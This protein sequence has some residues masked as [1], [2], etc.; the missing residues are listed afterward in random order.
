MKA[1]FHIQSA[2]LA[3]LCLIQSISGAQTAP[4]EGQFIAHEW[5]TFTAVQGSNG[6]PLGGMNHEEEALPSF[7]I[8]RDVLGETLRRDCPRTKGMPICNDDVSGPVIHSGDVTQKMETPVLYFHSDRER[9]VNVQIDFPQGIISQYFPRPLYF[10]PALNHATSLAGGSATFQVHIVNGALPVP[11]VEPLSVYRP[12]REVEANYLSANGENEKFIF[13]RGLGHFATS[14]SVSSSQGDLTL[15]NR[16]GERLEAVFLL[17]VSPQG[18]G[19]I[20]ALGGVE[21]N[22]ALTVA[23]EDVQRLTHAQSAP[24]VFLKNAQS[25]INAALERSGLYKDEAAA[26]TNTWKRSYFKN[27]GLRVLYILNRAETERLLPMNVSPKP[28]ELIRSLVGRI[29]IFTDVEER[30]LLGQFE[31]GSVETSSLGRF[32]EPKLRRL[33]EL[34]PN[35]QITERIRGLLP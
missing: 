26:M 25:Q 6:V 20:Q 4:V 18:R 14:L 7:V 17:N 15:S 29:E 23:N 8:G 16:S 13:Y 32:A 22:R 31:K 2:A 12:A 5:G 9:Q 3:V 34:S 35:A 11:E 1:S 28:Q 27:P 24:E 10:T 19:F 33:L 21:A 30:D